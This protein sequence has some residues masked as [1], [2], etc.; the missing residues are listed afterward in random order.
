MKKS[1][2]VTVI[3]YG[4]MKKEERQKLKNYYLEGM[5]WR[6]PTREEGL[7]IENYV[8]QNRSFE[9]IYLQVA[10]LMAIGVVVLF[11][12]LIAICSESVIY[13]FIVGFSALLMCVYAFSL[14]RRVRA[15][16]GFYEAVC[17]NDYQVVTGDCRS[18][19]HHPLSYLTDYVIWVDGERVVVTDAYKSDIVLRLPCKVLIVQ[20]G[21]YRF[22]MKMDEVCD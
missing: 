5:I 4:K 19:Y 2:L 20:G 3:C 9:L 17:R 15:I 21:S 18:M 13:R 1:N 16:L 10:F 22:V 11:G 12:G 8:E 6:N 14:L 7:F